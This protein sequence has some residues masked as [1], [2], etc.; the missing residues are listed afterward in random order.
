MAGREMEAIVFDMFETGLGVIRSLGQKGIKVTGIDFKK[1]IG[2][3]SRYV[4][5]L[6]CP[7]PIEQENEFI[8]WIQSN[9][10][11][12]K[13]KIPVFL[14]SDD[15]LSSFSRNRDVLSNYFL[16]NLADHSLLESIS[17]KYS[18]S[19][20]A[21]KAGI[22][23]PSTWLINETSDLEKIP[24]NINYPVFIKGQD[25][26]SWRKE[27]GGTIKGYLVNDS[28]ELYAKVKE[29]V[30]KNV[31]VIL[32]EVIKGPDTNHFKYC[33]YTTY[34]GEILAE[35]TLQKIRQNPIHFGVGAVVE[36]IYKPEV[37]EAGRKLFSNIG[38]IGI[39]SAEFKFDN[40]DG[41]LKLI[42]INPRYW[43]QNYLSTACGINFP[44]L[45]Y[46]D[47]LQMSPEPVPDFKKGIKWVNRYMD[48]DS[49]V[50]YRKEGVLSF[51]EWRRSL[52]GKKIYPD[53]TW[54]DPL[55][56]FYEVGFGKKIYKIPGFLWKKL[57]R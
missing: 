33:S 29:I 36:S 32:Q 23:L 30:A 37:I 44:Y 41:K 5:P 16:F 50:K 52:K 54:D 27:I 28:R 1:D 9:F 42:E 46:L 24:N 47:L 15:F 43:Q 56:L 45:N 21:F 14:T 40:R 48:F 26:N 25:V 19:Q 39:G 22:D 17:N 2:W 11:E 49:F 6:K 57:F 8:E 35:F 10:S 12:K 7:H 3:Y 20:L 13:I 4:R 38:F 51:S 34:S 31:P 18:Q 55:P 53:F